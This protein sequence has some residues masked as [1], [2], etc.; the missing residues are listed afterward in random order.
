ME[1][2]M[3]VFGLILLNVFFYNVN[4]KILCFEADNLFQAFLLYIF[5]FPMFVFIFVA[6]LGKSFGK[7]LRALDQFVSK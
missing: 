1:I 2:A 7:A 6:L 4:E 5:S 3:F